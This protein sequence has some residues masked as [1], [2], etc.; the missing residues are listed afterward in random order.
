MMDL[1]T[2]ALIEIPSVLKPA[3]GCGVIAFND[4]FLFK[5]GG[6]NS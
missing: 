3:H 5:Y 1:K 2:S 4:E 6:I